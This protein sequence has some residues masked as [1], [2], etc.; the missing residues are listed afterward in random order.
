MRSLLAATLFPMLA[1]SALGAPPP[2]AQIG[3]SCPDQGASHVP[4]AGGVLLP[5][6]T[7][8]LQ[9]HVLGVVIAVG[10]GRC[11][12]GHTYVAAHEECLGQF[13]PGMRCDVV[14]SIPVELEL[15]RCVPHSG[16]GYSYSTCECRAVG[17]MGF[18]DAGQTVE[19]H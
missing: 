4:A 15:C 14:G 5:W 11:P 6:R 16:H 13:A 2:R 8:Y 9:V 1:L 19:C 17:S 18:V 3:G 10:T 7:C 12:T